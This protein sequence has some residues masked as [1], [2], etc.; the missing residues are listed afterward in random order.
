MLF[1]STIVMVFEL[2]A[3]MVGMTGT[4]AIG[5]KTGAPPVVP[6]LWR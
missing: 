3:P 4:P 2:A 1:D 6:K 5:V